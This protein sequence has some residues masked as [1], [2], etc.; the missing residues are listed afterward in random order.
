[1]KLYTIGLPATSLR[2]TPRDCA[3]GGCGAGST[4]FSFGRMGEACQVDTGPKPESLNIYIYF[5]FTRQSKCLHSICVCELLQTRVSFACWVS[6]V[7]SLLV[8]STV[9]GSAGAGSPA[10]TFRR[11][12]DCQVDTGPK[13]ESLSLSLFLFSI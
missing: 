11:I 7:G 6:M 10:F 9:G 13:P 4:V 8:G 1:M 2:E 3:S 5:L 12:G